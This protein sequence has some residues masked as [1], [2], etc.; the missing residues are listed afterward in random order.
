MLDELE[1]FKLC[2]NRNIKIEFFYTI[3]KKFAKTQSLEKY[4]QFFAK[5][6]EIYGLDPLI[7]KFFVNGD[8]D[9]TE[10]S[11]FLESLE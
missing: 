4:V 3:A 2:P 9:Y 1:K 6:I 10:M 11:F 7:V 8:R 5:L